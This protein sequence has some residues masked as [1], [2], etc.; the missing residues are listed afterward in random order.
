[1]LWRHLQNMAFLPTRVNKYGLVSDIHFT[2][3]GILV[4]SCDLFPR[5]MGGADG[6]NGQIGENKNG[7]GRN[8]DTSH[9]ASAHGGWLFSSDDFWSK[10]SSGA[11]VFTG[12]WREN[13]FFLGGN[14][15]CG[16]GN[17]L[18]ADVPGCQRGL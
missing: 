13:C 7:S 12:V 11:A 9:G 15:H 8:T 14:S 16:G 4:Y 2:E 1:M 17:I 10:T 18:S 6:G 3:N 5:G